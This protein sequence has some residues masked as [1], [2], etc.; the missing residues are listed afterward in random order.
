MNGADDKCRPR[1]NG[2]RQRRR[3]RRRRRRREEE[4]EEREE[5]EE[6]EEEVEE[7]EEC[8][9]IVSLVPYKDP[10][11][12]KY[13]GKGREC[14]VKDDVATCQCVRKC[15]K[16]LKSVCGDDGKLY[17]NHCELHRMSC[18]TQ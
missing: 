18:V 1:L 17:P 4:E 5:E 3:R 10:C 12:I 11:L 14:I 16:H 2:K 7:E 15:S 9:G 8:L 13:C 6:E